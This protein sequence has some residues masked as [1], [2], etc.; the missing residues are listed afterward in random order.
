VTTSFRNAL[1]LQAQIERAVSEGSQ[2]EN[3]V[4]GIKDE[5][6]KECG[7]GRGTARR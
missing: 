2:I 1:D 5:R 4:T 7:S 3:D 6:W